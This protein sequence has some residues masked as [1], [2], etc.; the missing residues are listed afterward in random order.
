ME[1]EQI[2]QRQKGYNYKIVAVIYRNKIRIKAEINVIDPPKRKV[3]EGPKVVQSNPP[4]KEAGKRPIPS[5][6]A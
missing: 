3:A 2:E 1:K 5:K 4:I 6:V